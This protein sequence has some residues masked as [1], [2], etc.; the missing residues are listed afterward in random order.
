VLIGIVAL[1]G[2]ILTLGIGLICIIPMLCLLVPVAV[3]VSIY[4]MLSQVA[5]VVENTGIMD[6]LRRGW[7][8]VKG[9]V[10][11]VLVMALVLIVGGFVVGLII[12]LPAILLI[13]PL[14]AGVA[15]GTQTSITS[16]VVIFGL[17]LV[18]YLPVAIF[19]NG[20]LQTFV[21]GSWTVTYRRL[22]GRSGAENLAAKPA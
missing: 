15:L 16:G 14:I 13:A 1:G 12:G 2:T 6:G 4:A 22:T 5:V 10:G 19:L 7:A 8:L 17:C 9:N 21:I 3:A 20:I 11:P 18:I